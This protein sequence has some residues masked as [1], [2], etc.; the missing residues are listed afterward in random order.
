[1]LMIREEELLLIRSKVEIIQKN[2]HDEIVIT[3][4]S[5]SG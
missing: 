5:L 3:A 2:N 4:T 1:M